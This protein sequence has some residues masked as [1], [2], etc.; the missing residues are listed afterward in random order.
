MAVRLLRVV[1]AIEFLVAL[2]AVLSVWREVGG[3]YHLDLMPW[4]LKLILT[5]GI[6]ASIVQ[7]TAAHIAENRRRFLLWGC[8]LMIS[9]LAS[10]LVTFYY[11]L[12]EPPDDDQ[13]AAPLSALLR[14]E[15]LSTGVHTL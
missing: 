13:E 12:N 1:Y 15:S 6:A 14:T 11:H 9:I 8:A 7:A 10:G 2:V 5:L 3:Q 4:Y